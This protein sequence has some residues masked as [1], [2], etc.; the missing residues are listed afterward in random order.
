MSNETL[1]RPRDVAY[2]S[3]SDRLLVLALFIVTWAIMA[4]FGT[5]TILW[6]TA[7]T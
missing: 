7:S 3:R 4:A 6:L 1:K 2:L 5:Y